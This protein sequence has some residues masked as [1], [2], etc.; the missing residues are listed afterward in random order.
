M[1]ISL[2]V[3]LV[4]LISE[5]C[6]KEGEEFANVSRVG[7]NKCKWGKYSELSSIIFTA[8][9]AAGKAMRLL[10]DCYLDIV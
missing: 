6:R 3:L 4:D 10:F 1:I 9:P 5:P 7:V 2:F 8:N